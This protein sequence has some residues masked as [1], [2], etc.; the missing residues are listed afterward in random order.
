LF[1]P[2]DRTR[3]LAVMCQCLLV[4]MVLRKVERRMEGEKSPATGAIRRPGL[5]IV[6][7]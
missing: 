1:G 4:L 5:K 2:D 6:R 7:Q 3:A